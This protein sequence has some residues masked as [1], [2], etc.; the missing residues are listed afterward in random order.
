VKRMSA[1]V[2]V[3]AM[4]TTS[5]SAITDNVDVDVAGIA[6]AACNTVAET[7]AAAVVRQMEQI[8]VD[9]S[10]PIPDVD[11]SSM[12]SSAAGLGCSPSQMRA[13]IE[14]K[15]DAAGVDTNRAKEFLDGILNE[16]D[17]N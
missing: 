13:L 7:F 8:S 9:P 1:I 17:S 16:V 15:A 3:L 10:F 14:E 2:L 4:F 5:C 6:G 11:V 12:L